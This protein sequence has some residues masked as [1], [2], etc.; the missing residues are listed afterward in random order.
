MPGRRALPVHRSNRRT[1]ANP[2]GTMSTVVDLAPARPGTGAQPTG[3]VLTLSCP[4]RPGIVRAV[5]SFLADRGF[6]ITEHQQFDDHTD[7]Q[8]FLRTA[9]RGAPA[10][11]TTAWLTADF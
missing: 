6:D 1:A 9:F 4:E 5:A 2:E 11:A 3:F 7:G 8:L 10:G